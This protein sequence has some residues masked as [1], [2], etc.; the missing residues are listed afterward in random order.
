MLWWFKVYLTFLE[1]SE[2]L[3][4]RYGIEYRFMTST[5]YITI[6]TLTRSFLKVP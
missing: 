3:T 1:K 4:T 6:P 5:L 2:D